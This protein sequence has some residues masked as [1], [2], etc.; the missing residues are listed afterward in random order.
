MKKKICQNVGVDESKSNQTC[1][2]YIAVE[3]PKMRNFLKV[4]LSA[5]KGSFGYLEVKSDN[6]VVKLQVNGVNH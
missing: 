2:N 5:N 1:K 4:Y 6:M 3:K